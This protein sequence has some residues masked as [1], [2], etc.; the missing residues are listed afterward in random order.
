MVSF[1]PFEL[2][3]IWQLLAPTPGQESTK[4]QGHFRQFIKTNCAV[5][6]IFRLVTSLPILL[7]LVS[8][9]SPLSSLI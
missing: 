6:L 1:P 3:S 7:A 5:K 2:K 8:R 9:L 4:Q